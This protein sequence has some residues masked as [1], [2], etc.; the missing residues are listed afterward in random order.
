[1]NKDSIEENKAIQ[2]GL[3]RFLDEELAGVRKEQV[4]PNRS[5]KMSEYSELHKI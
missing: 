1:M 3:E 4:A 5:T 2:D